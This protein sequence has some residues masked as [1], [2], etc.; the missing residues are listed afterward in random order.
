VLVDNPGW[1][2]VPG[3]CDPCAPECGFA[4]GAIDVDMAD[5]DL[6]GDLDLVATAAHADRLFW[7][8]NAA[9]DGS[10]WTT[11]N[12]ANPGNPRETA[13]A[14]VDGDGDTDVF[15][16]N[17]SNAAFGPLV[18][19]G[20]GASWVENVLLPGPPPFSAGICSDGVDNDGDCRI[21]YPADPGCLSEE[22][23]MENALCNDALDNDGDGLVDLQDP[24]CGDPEALLENPRCDDGLDNDLDGGIDWNGDPPDP[25]CIDQPWR[26]Y[27]GFGAA[28][29]LGAGL[30]L[31]LPV[32][33]WLRRGGRSP[34]A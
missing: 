17:K 26:D 33:L 31:L 24:G 23:D 20:K 2:G 27:E 10:Q 4:D 5:L 13:L 11:R 25:Q 1:E 12:L 3:Q 32:L 16:V 22:D 19:P 8:E 7:L 18:T 15:Y 9:G 34:S 30:V 14:D 29:G 28:C 21:D 6:D